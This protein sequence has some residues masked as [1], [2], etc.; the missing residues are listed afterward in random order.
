MF[1]FFAKLQFIF[2][3]HLFNDKKDE[4]GRQSMLKKNPLILKRSYNKMSAH[5]SNYP[6]DN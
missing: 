2:D 1:N 4:F 5:R 6:K 3:L